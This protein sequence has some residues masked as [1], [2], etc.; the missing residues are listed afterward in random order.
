MTPKKLIRRIRAALKK[1]D[2]SDSRGTV[3]KQ[4][5]FDQRKSIREHIISEYQFE[6]DLLDLFED[7]T[8]FDDCSE[9]LI[10]K[11]H[12]YIPIYDRYFSRYRGKKVRFLEIGVSKGG[13]LALWRKYF[14]SEAIIYGI[15]I[16][17]KCEQYNGLHGQVRIG[18]QNDENFLRSVIKEM[19]GVDVILDDGSHQ[20]KHIVESLNV[21]L[22]EV[23]D[24]GIYM[25]ED[26][27]T[28]YWQEFGGGF[29]KKE[30]FFSTLRVLIDDLHHWYHSR[31]LQMPE[32]SKHCQSIHIHDSVVIIEKGR[33]IK[34]T[35]SQVIKGM[36]KPE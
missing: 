18:S 17:P 2:T 15:D 23:N 11:W 3:T 24:G 34:P 9:V 36:A 1:T 7:P 35:H 32:V 16:N 4:L 30:N 6:G 29:S 10:H 12:H 28:S 27:H 8:G 19:G 33:L 26:L 20:M 31:G 14:G 13:S 21:L 5:K 22:K 25:I